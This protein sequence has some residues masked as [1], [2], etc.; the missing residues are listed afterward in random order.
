MSD[1]KDVI[2]LM[3]VTYNR[4]DL[5]K[6]T[7]QSIEDNTKTYY[8]LVIVDNG[9]EDGTKEFLEDYKPHMNCAKYE[10]V[11]NDE[12]KGIAIGRNQCLKGAV[13]LDTDWFCTM[14]NDVE[15]PD[16]WL[17]E[18]VNIMTANPKYAMIGVNMEDIKYPMITSN[19][20][21]FQTK[22]RGNLGTACIVFQAKLQK[23]LGY[24]N[25]EYGLYGEEDA[26]YGMRARVAGF[27]LGYIETMGNH[28][29]VGELDQGEYREFKTEMHKNNLAQFNANCGAYA[30]REKQL[31]IPYKED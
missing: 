9:S 4:L 22:P 27:G 30:R 26:D 17:S 5:T 15:V 16:G 13:A 14:D 21:T 1:N 12:N 10:T 18:C 31:Y 19:D 24:F 8:N 28:F 23:M 7:L 20:Y 2:T 6:R 25:T 3:M 29:G 11:F